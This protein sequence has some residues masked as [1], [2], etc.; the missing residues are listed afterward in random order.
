M[1]RFGREIIF[2]L[3]KIT[4]EIKIFCQKYNIKMTALDINCNIISQFIPEK[5]NKSYM[6]LPIPYKIKYDTDK[7]P[8]KE[9]VENMLDTKS[10][11]QLQ[12]QF[13]TKRPTSYS[14]ATLTVLSSL[15]NPILR[16]KF[17][18]MFPITLS[19]IIFDSAQSAD[20]IIS[21]DAVF[22]Y[23]YFDFEAA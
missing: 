7:F 9:I 12:N 17:Y 20:D 21:A 16:V 5:I 4:N 15:N 18:N 11:S 2:H 10:L 14:D 23:D 19:D 3:S 8:F 22:M 13:N 6:Y 1:Q